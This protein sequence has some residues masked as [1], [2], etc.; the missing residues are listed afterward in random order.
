MYEVGDSITYK[1]TIK[2]D[3]DEDYMIDEDSF[4]T[5]SEYIKYTLNKKEVED[6]KLT[7]DKFDASNSLK[8]SLYT[9][10]KEQP[11]DVIATDIV[12]E[13]VDPKEI[14]NSVT[15]TSSKMLISF[16]LLTTVVIAYILLKRKNKYTKYIM[17]VLLMSL[18]PTAY[19]ICKCDIEVETNIEIEK[20]LSGTVYV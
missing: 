20:S 3:S 9:S 11:L 1:V 12:K 13:S 19:A 17:F 18:I 14:K 5:D 8:L 2:N 7:N 15:S 16:V 10:E 4:K 6:D